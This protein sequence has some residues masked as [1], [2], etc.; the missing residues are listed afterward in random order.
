MTP[1]EHTVRRAPRLRAEVR[2]R[3]TV[4]PL[5]LFFDL[6]FVLAFTQCTA[7]MGAEENW[8]SVAR[9]CLVL[10]ILWW[11]WTAYAWLTSLV[12]PEEGSVRLV[13]IAAMSALLVAALCLPESFGDRALAFAIAYGVV[14]LAHIVLFLLPGRDDDELRH[15]V[16]AIAATSAI[17]VS[18]LIAGTFLDARG[19]MIVWTVAILLDLAGGLL[20]IA[21]WRIVPA[22]FSERHGLIVIL[23]LGESIVA[24]GIGAQVELTTPVLVAAVL[25]VTLASALWWTYFDVVSIVTE[26]RLV[27]A[28]EGLERNRLARD[29]YSY[30]HLVLVMGIILGALGLEGTLHHVDEP[31]D[32]QHAF[33][34]FGGVAIYLLG[35]VALRLRNA[36]T[37][38]VQRLVLACILLVGVPI[39]TEIDALASLSAV[40]VVLWAM[41]A[42]ETHRY[43]TNRYDLRHG[44]Q[45]EPGEP[46]GGERR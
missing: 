5:E 45:P 21:G 9:G 12:E 29:S 43:G 6:V 18:L 37:L 7:L 4:K 13:M 3:E 35:H 34:L 41:I 11:C 30:L 22:H 8:T 10:A 42:F 2:E 33:G 1:E 40:N 27:R 28:A 23:A 17:G 19:Q 32:A 36:R 26:Q 31:L 20:R 44:V 14:R 38:N 24:L 15:S 46:I 25:G 39:A 16:L